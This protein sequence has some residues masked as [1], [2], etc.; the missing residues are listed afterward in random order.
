MKKH[1]RKVTYILWALNAAI[2][3]FNAYLFWPN[4]TGG[5]IVALVWF[6]LYV[7]TTEHHRRFYDH[8]L[9]W[10]DNL[11][12]LLNN[13]EKAHVEKVNRSDAASDPDREAHVE[14]V[15]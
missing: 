10:T 13:A 1:S 11:V 2:L 5:W 14:S 8:I 7:A 12:E 4:G 6:M 15:A 3:C 9:E